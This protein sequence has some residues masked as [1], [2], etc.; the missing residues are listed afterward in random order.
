MNILQ[1]LNVL[2]IAILLLALPI[3]YM[4]FR[5]RYNKSLGLHGKL[6]WTDKGKKTASFRNKKFFVFG[7]PDFIYKTKYGLTAV[8][9][10][11]RNGGIYLSDIIQVMT[12]SLSARG[13]GKKIKHAIVIT[14]TQRKE[15]TLP[16]SDKQLYSKIQSYVEI[17]RQ[18]ENGNSMPSTPNKYKCMSCAFT[19]S[20]ND[21]VS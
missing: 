4:A 20:C 17:V 21:R 9:Y 6:I 15:I 11:S 12:A 3:A 16:K 18:A 2:F 14:N 10:K 13:A 19:N 5:P 8:E 1:D 7:K